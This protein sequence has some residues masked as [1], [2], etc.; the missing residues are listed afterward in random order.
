MS[1]PG[2]AEKRRRDARSAGWRL[3]F[4]PR[5]H[6]YRGSGEYRGSGNKRIGT[7]EGT[8]NGW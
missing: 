8:G 2:M 3:S 1:A 7:G 6:I 4:G 5:F